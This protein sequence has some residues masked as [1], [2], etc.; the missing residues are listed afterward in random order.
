MKDYKTQTSQLIKMNVVADLFHSNE[1]VRWNSG[2][3]LGGAGYNGDA[4][5]KRTDTLR[6][7]TQHRAYAYS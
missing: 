4:Q 7:K 1:N 6:G 3:Q 2:C 5:V